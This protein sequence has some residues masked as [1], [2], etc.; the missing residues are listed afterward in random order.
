MGVDGGMIMP[1][2]DEATGD[3]VS[4]KNIVILYVDVN[5]I[6]D[7]E[8]GRLTI[9]TTGRGNGY[10]ISD[11]TSVAISWKRT[12]GE[13]FELTTTDGTPIAFGRGTTYFGLIS[14]NGAV[15]RN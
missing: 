4:F 3:S 9:T 10:Y 13:N 8:E 15:T 6:K 14:S 5:R 1:M 12:A 7:D 2:V 11:G